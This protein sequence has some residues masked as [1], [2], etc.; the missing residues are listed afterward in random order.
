MLVL[1]PPRTGPTHLVL[2]RPVQ[3]PCSVP[4]LPGA[5]WSGMG[6]GALP[7]GAEGWGGTKPSIW[8]G[9]RYVWFTYVFF[10]FFFHLSILPFLLTQTCIHGEKFLFF[11]F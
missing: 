2:S 11:N 9:L 8:L 5:A 3:A 10:F 6:A 1:G 7:S 4:S